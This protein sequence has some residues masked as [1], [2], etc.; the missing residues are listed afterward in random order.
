MT[1]EIITGVPHRYRGVCKKCETDFRADWGDRRN[2][3]PEDDTI[4]CI[5][6]NCPSCGRETALYIDDGE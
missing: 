2:R 4:G 1:V 5:E 3:F 6:V